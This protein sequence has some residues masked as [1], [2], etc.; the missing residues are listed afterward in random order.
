MF[1]S[2]MAHDDH[3][4]PLRDIPAQVKKGE[5]QSFRSASINEIF[6]ATSARQFALQPP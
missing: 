6:V 4:S 2:A 1:S 5:N 3:I